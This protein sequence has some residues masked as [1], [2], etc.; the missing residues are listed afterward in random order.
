MSQFSQPNAPSVGSASANRGATAS[1]APRAPGNDQ[2]SLR[3]FKDLIRS[4]FRHAQADNS[5]DEGINGSQSSSSSA[6]ESDS[7]EDE[8]DEE[9]EED[10]ESL[11]EG[12]IGDVAAAMEDDVENGLGA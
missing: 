1:S 9:E 5:D 2:E 6:L 3:I 4:R 7:E 8:D 11:D 12:L 10:A